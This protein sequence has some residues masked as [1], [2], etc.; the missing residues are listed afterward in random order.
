MAQER[1]E[2]CGKPIG[3]LGCTWCNEQDYIDYQ[4]TQDEQPE[5]NYK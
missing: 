5:A 4:A 3:W 1:C 2:D